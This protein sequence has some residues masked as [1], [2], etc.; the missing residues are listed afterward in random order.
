MKNQILLQT[1]DAAFEA[2]DIAEAIVAIPEEA[3]EEAINTFFDEHPEFDL[4]FFHNRFG[5]V[6]SYTSKAFTRKTQISLFPGTV[7]S[8]DTTL[9]ELLE[10]IL[11]YRFVTLLEANHI[12]YLIDWQDLNKAPMTD[13]LFS[14]ISL[15]EKSMRRLLARTYESNSV[16]LLTLL[17][18]HRREKVVSI[19]EF[20]R[21][22]G[23]ET[24][25]INCFYLKDTLHAA[26][27]LGFLDEL[28][29]GY[30]QKD[31]RL[32]FINEANEL[33][34]NVAHSS[35]IL[36][37]MDNLEKL[38]STVQSIRYLISKEFNVPRKATAQ[39]SIYSVS[40]AKSA[41]S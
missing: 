22:K 37:N 30:V 39:P 17:P 14:Q 10:L 28:H 33:R 9:F 12:K 40:R 24:N 32:N 27:Q 13:W 34:N 36:E 11:E 21:R 1:Y 16:G 35:F 29:T 38:Y 7:V 4:A 5:E 3:T 18:G 19:F 26:E 8:R 41:L 23:A 31:E 15:L 25:L 20:Q 2:M 6:H